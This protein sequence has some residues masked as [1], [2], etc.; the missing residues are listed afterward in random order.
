MLVE[1]GIEGS[2]FF[3]SPVLFP[4]LSVRPFSPL[5]NRPVEPLVHTI[6]ADPSLFY[7][8]RLT[9]PFSFSHPSHSLPFLFLDDTPSR[10]RYFIYNGS[11]VGLYF[12]HCKCPTFFLK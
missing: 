11:T 6:P 10:S 3:E 12:T 9:F 2:V 4:H 5:G 8:S 7:L 1:G